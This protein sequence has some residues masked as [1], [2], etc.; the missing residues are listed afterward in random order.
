[1]NIT[2]IDNIIDNQIDLSIDNQLEK[3]IIKNSLINIAD[4]YFSNVS[5]LLHMD[6][7]QDSQTII[8]SSNNNFTMTAFGDAKIDTSIKKFGSGAAKFDGSGDTFITSDNITLE[9]GST[10]TI[11]FWAYLNTV[12]SNQVFLSKVEFAPFIP[13]GISIIQDGNNTRNLMI[14]KDTNLYSFNTIPNTGEWFHV[15]VT[16][17]AANNAGYLFFNG[18]LVNTVALLGMQDNNAPF[19]LGATGFPNNGVG[20]YLNGYID[21][22]RVTKGVCRY[23]SSF[24]PQTE[25]FPNS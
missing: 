17:S 2:R 22:V 10:Y 14:Y 5:L 24:T 25:P 15:A 18:N 13:V 9:L 23:T 7:A 21:E 11:E 1:M 20:N 12:T 3:K 4:P 16:S 8:D 19:R 6:G